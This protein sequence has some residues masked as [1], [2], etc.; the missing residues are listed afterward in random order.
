MVYGLIVG[1][2]AN[3]FQHVYFRRFD[4]PQWS[5]VGFNEKGD[6][7]STSFN[8]MELSTC[9]DRTHISQAGS[10]PIAQIE[11]QSHTSPITIE[12]RDGRPFVDSILE[13]LNVEYS[14]ALFC[15]VPKNLAKNLREGINRKATSDERYNS[16][17]MYQE[18]F[19]K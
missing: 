4:K 2:L 19:E 7:D 6:D 3:I 16:I 12:V 15:C 10:V 9:R 18:S 11:N 13:D 1:M 5:T 8:E 14:S 17:R